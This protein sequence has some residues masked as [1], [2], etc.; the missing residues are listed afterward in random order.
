MKATSASALGWISESRRDGLAF[1]VHHA[2]EQVPK[3]GWLTPSMSMTTLLV[4]PIFL[5]TTFSPA[6]SRRWHHALLDLVGVLDGDV[7][8]ARAQRANGFARRLTRAS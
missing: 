5:P 7:R 4:T 3:S 6:S 8:A 2:V 1:V